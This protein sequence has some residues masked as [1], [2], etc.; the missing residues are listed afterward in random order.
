M[1]LSCGI[2]TLGCK[3]NQYESRA[4]AELLAAQDVAIRPFEDVCDMYL[5]H[6][7]T[8]TAESDR[9][10]RQMTRRAIRR[11]PN[12]VIA[13]CGCAVQKDP[14]AIAQIPGVSIV[15]GNRRK[16]ELVSAALNQ[17][18][19][20]RPE[21]PLILCGNLDELPYEDMRISGFD[22]IRAYVKIEDGCNANCAYCIIPKVRGPQTSRPM[23]SVLEEIS[24]L[25]DHGCREVV[26]TGI[27]TAAYR[28]DLGALLE[29][30]DRIEGIDRIR[31]S[32]VDPASLKPA[33]MEKMASLPHLMPH[34]HISLQSGCSRTLARMRRRYNAQTAMERLTALRRLM[35]QVQFSADVI[36]GFPGE[37]EED[38]AE[39][40]SFVR[41]AEFLHLHVF[42]YSRRPGTEAAD[43]PDQIDPSEKARRVALLCR[44]GEQ[45]RDAILARLAAGRENVTV[46]TEETKDGFVLGHSEAFVPCRIPLR[47]LLPSQHRGQLVACKITGYHDGALTVA[48]R[49]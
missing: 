14:Q 33:L 40:L 49:E 2:L 16:T 28:Y 1:S 48:P 32:S 43:M 45:T 29:Q 19:N 44:T 35:P 13:V 10:V 26:L 36:A 21:S 47:D 30:I 5:I 22:R 42:P 39:S 37:S 24:V 8:V 17:L 11:N 12:A 41:E 4:M 23:E 38:F 9:K 34:F 3:V 46:L 7:C 6:S 27:E 18:Q 20:G 15:C 31:L 25:R